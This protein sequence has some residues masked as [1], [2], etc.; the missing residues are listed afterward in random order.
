MS[1]CYFHNFG[2]S[3]HRLT[4]AKKLGTETSNVQVKF[5]SRVAFHNW[6]FQHYC[7]FILHL[8]RAAYAKL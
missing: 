1:H 2:F 5:F 4:F 6:Y 8:I 3:N 7:Y